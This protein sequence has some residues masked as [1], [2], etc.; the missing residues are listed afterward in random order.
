MRSLN[1]I[2]GKKSLRAEIVRIQGGKCVRC[3]GPFYMAKVRKNK[4]HPDSPTVDHCIATANGGA[5][6][7]GNYTGLHRKCNTAKGDEPPTGCELIW[8]AAIGAQLHGWVGKRDKYRSG[9]K[10]F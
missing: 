3:G 6:E 4:Y 1:F 2:I 8:A 9:D 10:I 5:D 7:I